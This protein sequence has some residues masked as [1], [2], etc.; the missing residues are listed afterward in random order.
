MSMRTFN[1][2]FSVIVIALCFFFWQDAASIRPPAHIYPKT[3]IAVA[4]FLAFSLLLQSLFFP[5][6]LIQRNPFE[7]TKWFRVLTI[8]FATIIYYFAVK[9]IGFYVSSFIFII[10]TTWFLGDRTINIKVFG[11]LA[12]LSLVLNVIVYASFK[13]FLKVPTP[14][15][16][17]F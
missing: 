12:T 5:S 10:I 13:L 7:G 9:T 15:G 4:G 11:R 2:I 14:T 1:Y 17:L 6:S 16:I 3:I 8:I